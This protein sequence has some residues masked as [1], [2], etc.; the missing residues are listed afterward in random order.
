MP[1]LLGVGNANYSVLNTTGTSTLN[2]GSGGAVASQPG[3]LYGMVTIAPGTTFAA[4]FY[5]IIA[6]PPGGTSTTTTTN[7]LMASSAGT[8]GQAFAAGLAGVGVRYR[9]ALVVVTSGTAGQINA[10]WD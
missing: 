10:L 9:G 3:V 8:A 2:P 1:A 5:D 4:A 7:Q 6:P